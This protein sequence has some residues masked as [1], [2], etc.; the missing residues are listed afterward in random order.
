MRRYSLAHLTAIKASPRRLI[1]LAAGAGYDFVGLRLRDVLPG[2]GWPMAA[3]STMLLETKRALDDHG[4]ALLDVELAKLTPDTAIAD[5]RPL[6]DSAAELGAR[7]IL[8]QAHDDDQVRL[9]ENF[10]ALADLASPYGLTIDVEFLTWTSMRGV[11][12][13]L[14]LL[15]AS[16]RT[17]VGLVVDTLHFCRSQCTVEDLEGVPASLLH[18]IQL[19]DAKPE[20]PESI[21][22]LIHTAR[23]DRLLPG[24]GGL[25]LVPILQRLPA[26]TIIGIEIPSHRLSAQ[27][28]DEVRVQRALA[29]A[30]SLVARAESIV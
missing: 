1:E 16:G 10:N 21:Q 5:F 8:A 20:I 17:N 18:F 22:G 25:D 11:A 26:E 6:L 2:D 30:K 15:E 9:L 29:Q 19:A 14:E 3:G 4:V 28:I 12:N 24:D 23:E 13:V 7:H 27:I